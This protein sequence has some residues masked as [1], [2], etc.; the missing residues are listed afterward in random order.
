MGYSF[1]KSNLISFRPS[2]R[3][4]MSEINFWQLP[5]FSDFQRCLQTFTLNLFHTLL[6]S[7]CLR[8]TFNLS[9]HP[10][11]SVYLRVTFHLFHTLLPEVGIAIPYNYRVQIIIYKEGSSSL[12]INVPIIFHIWT[13]ILKLRFFYLL[14]FLIIP[15]KFMLFWFSLRFLYKYDEFQFNLAL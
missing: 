3:R 7:I 13:T 9:Y 10:L 1:Q 4:S 6:G 11:G 2:N 5:H 14:F 15:L 12:N 8:V